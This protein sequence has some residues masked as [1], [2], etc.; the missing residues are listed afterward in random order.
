[1]ASETN[2]VS[3]RE[4]EQFVSSQS[5]AGA[6]APTVSAHTSRTLVETSAFV[7]E[8]DTL[9]IA[10]NPATIPSVPSQRMDLSDT[11]ARV[12]LNMKR[13]PL[14][15]QGGR[16]KQ[17]RVLRDEADEDEVMI[18]EIQVNEEVEHPRSEGFSNRIRR[19]A[20]GCDMR[21]K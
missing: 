7:R 13:S 16:S 6:S 2:P 1:M 8:N 20:K 4:R 14:D 21:E 10:K 12:C 3:G 15:S 18:D 11:P 19:L 5:T 9:G 17:R